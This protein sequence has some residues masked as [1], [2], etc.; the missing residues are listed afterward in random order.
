MNGTLN[1]LFME[2][3]PLAPA[4]GIGLKHQLA[5]TVASPKGFFL[6][7]GGYISYPSGSKK[8]KFNYRRAF[9][10]FDAGKWRWINRTELIN[11][12]LAFHVA[13]PIDG[14]VFKA[15]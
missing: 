4:P 12:L 14:S 15:C 1:R 7:G 6:M 11:G 5:A 3:S 8:H 2:L 13:F 9:Y 10:E